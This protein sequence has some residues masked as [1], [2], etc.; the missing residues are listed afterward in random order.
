MVW[1]KVDHAH[2]RANMYNFNFHLL[3]ISFYFFEKANH[4]I[5]RNNLGRGNYFWGKIYNY[6][7]LIGALVASLFNAGH[8]GLIL[9]CY[10]SKCRSSFIISKLRSDYSYRRASRQ[11]VACWSP[12]VNIFMEYIYI[13]VYYKWRFHDKN[14][15]PK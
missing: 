3:F 5:Q 11:L 1:K 10:V 13:N 14:Q 2:M 8:Y 6:I 7:T 12:W 9:A 4:L 15:L